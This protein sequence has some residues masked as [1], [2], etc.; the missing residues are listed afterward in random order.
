MNMDEDRLLVKIAEMYY[1]EDKNQ[2][3]ISKE[4]HIH[5]ST[6]S[7]LLKRSRE[8]G[9]VQITINYDIA[10]SYAIERQLEDTFHLK[11]AIVVPASSNLQKEQKN[12]LL[13]DALNDYLD[14]VLM[15]H[16]TIGFSWGQTM[17]AVATCLKEKDTREI[18]CVPMIG[19]PSGRLIS[20]YHVNTITYE[21]ARKLKA[22]A[23]LIDSPAFP[24]TQELSDS[25][26]QNE[27]NQELQQ[28][29][30]HLDMAILGIGS[31]CLSVNETWQQFYGED[32]L[33]SL[34][35]K[36][37][38][39]DIVS[40]FYTD[41]GI[42]VV[43]GFDKRIIGITMEDLK[44]TPIRIGVAESPE[45]TTAIKGAL[46]GSYVNVLITT[47]ETAKGILTI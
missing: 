33:Q 24:E 11:K 10:G 16:M 37:V 4:L 5:R 32:V 34:H 8:E 7:R 45:K 35:E 18:V 2:S 9:I 12:M 28:Y 27:F 15:D 39:G 25:L 6:I 1:K 47:E 30:K 23:L 43:S 36:N 46:K 31:P 40:R 22:E 42:P 29:W 14:A 3:D 44:R 13:A 38:I 20:R 26:L 17:A 19:G 21:I 41:D